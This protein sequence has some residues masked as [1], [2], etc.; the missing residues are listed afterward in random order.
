MFWSSRA[1]PDSLPQGPGL[2][3]GWTADVSGPA[4]PPCPTTPPLTASTRACGHLVPTQH[5]WPGS[6]SH[7]Q[8]EDTNR[9]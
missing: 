9:Y 8:N 3:V 7:S 2:M 6:P 1:F 5:D 4:R